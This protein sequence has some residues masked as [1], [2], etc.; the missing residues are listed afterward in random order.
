MSLEKRLS[1]AKHTGNREKINRVFEEMFNEYSKLVAFII[2][3]YV[4]RKEDVEDLVNGVFLKVFRES[5]RTEIDNIKGY[6]IKTAKNASVDFLRQKE[7]EIEY[8]DE[9]L[10]DLPDDR[11]EKGNDYYELV[12]SMKRVLSE[13]L[14]NLILL[15]VVYG[16]SF[17]EIGIRYAVPE[18]S[19]KTD[20]YRAIRKLR[21]EM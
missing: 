13:R 17:K 20:Y 18:S 4:S 15:H 2:F 11:F 14:I 8:N 12:E 3:K 21:K 9:V 5:L 6:L 16:Y 10:L 19:V 1:K 7:V